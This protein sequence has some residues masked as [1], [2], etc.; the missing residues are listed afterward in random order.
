MIEL[1]SIF[2]PWCNI[3][4]LERGLDGELTQES[5]ALSELKWDDLSIILPGNGEA[6]GV[7][8][9]ALGP[10]F[11]RE[12]GRAM[13]ALQQDIVFLSELLRDLTG[14]DRV[15]VRLMRLL[16]PACPN[17]HFDRVGLRLVTT[18]S[19]PGTEYL[20]D[21]WTPGDPRSSANLPGRKLL[22][23]VHEP[24]RTSSAGDVVF[25]KGTLWEGNE[26]H[27]A[28]HRSPQFP[29]SEPRVVATLD[30]L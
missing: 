22:G 8:G 30:P 26:E 28:V 24:V 4:H 16:K 2:E 25:L 20:P 7:D 11:E 23:S 6:D 17:L 21:R 19:G 10:K 18:Y 1:A 29:S 9:S 13:P 5:E 15:G 27:G 14:A 3:A 12:F